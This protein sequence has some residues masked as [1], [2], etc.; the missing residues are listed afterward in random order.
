MHGMNRWRC[1]TASLRIVFTAS[2]PTQAGDSIRQR[3]HSLDWGA[4]PAAPTLPPKLLHPQI[5]KAPQCTL[6]RNPTRTSTE[7]HPKATQ[8]LRRSLGSAVVLTDTECRAQNTG[9]MGS[10]AEKASAAGDPPP[11]ANRGQRKTLIG[12]FTESLEDAHRLGRDVGRRGHGGCLGLGVRGGRMISDT[13]K[14]IARNN[15]ISHMSGEQATALRLPLGFWVRWKMTGD[16]SHLLIPA[17]HSPTSKSD[18][19][20]MPECTARR[21]AAPSEEHGHC[22]KQEIAREQL[23]PRPSGLVEGGGEL[24]GTQATATRCRGGGTASGRPWRRNRRVFAHDTR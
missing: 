16:A 8:P 11:K 22:G 17:I 7:S 6:N 5:Q 2:W 21:A 20:P 9:T 12:Y 1:A 14:E 10:G 4:E 18:S 13:F 19:P 24:A 23:A 15:L 3:A